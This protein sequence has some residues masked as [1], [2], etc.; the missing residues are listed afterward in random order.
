MAPVNAG[1]ISPK[2]G[3]RSD[4][5]TA[6]S[7]KVK[8]S[9]APEAWSPADNDQAELQGWG[10]YEIVDDG[11]LKVFFEIQAHGTRF[12]DDNITRD[13]VASRDKAGDPLAAK[14]QRVV[15]RS[16]AGTKVRKK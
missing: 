14:A 6:R 10:V 16:K 12:K 15:F 1:K 4:T 5:S 3:F 8:K 11:T 7:A 2:V 13:F 9:A